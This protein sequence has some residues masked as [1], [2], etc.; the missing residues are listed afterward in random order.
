LFSL[1]L[2]RLPRATLCPYTTLFRSFMTVEHLVPDVVLYLDTPR[3]I[4]KQRLNT[5][6]NSQ[7]LLGYLDP[8]YL[9][10]IEQ[11]FRLL[12]ETRPNIDRKSTRLNSSHVKISYAVFC[13]K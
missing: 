2:T 1:M 11:Y 4:L 12:V 5:R 3:R 9:S 13:L 7:E 8:R 10:C 6:A